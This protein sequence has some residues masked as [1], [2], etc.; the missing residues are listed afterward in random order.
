MLQLSAPDTIV[1][2]IQIPQQPITN[3]RFRVFRIDIPNRKLDRARKTLPESNDEIVCKFALKR[4]KQIIIFQA[5]SVLV[6]L[7]LSAKPRWFGHML[8]PMVVTMMYSALIII[9]SSVDYVKRDLPL[10][11]FLDDHGTLGGESLSMMIISLVLLAS[12]TLLHCFL[13]FGI[14]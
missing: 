4:C 14:T 5:L 2:V 6:D 10:F 9:F 13:V 1:L 11:S 12:V 7:F 3:F 8:G